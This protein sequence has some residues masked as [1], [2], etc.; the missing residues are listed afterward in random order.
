MVARKKVYVL[1]LVCGRE[2]Y[3]IMFDWVT[4][5]GAYLK[6]T[7]SK[8]SSKKTDFCS[9]QNKLAQNFKFLNDNRNDLC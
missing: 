8:L 2:I 7:F 1:N 4:D 3:Q 9:I 6:P 5:T